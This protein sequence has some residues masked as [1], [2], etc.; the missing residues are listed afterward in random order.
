MVVAGRGLDLLRTCLARSK[1]KKQKAA[2]RVKSLDYA[3]II[4]HLVPASICFF[5]TV[6]ILLR[7]YSPNGSV[8]ERVGTAMFYM[9]LGMMA[10]IGIV[11]GMLALIGIVVLIAVVAVGLC[12]LMAMAVC[13][14]YSTVETKP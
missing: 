14:Y 13:E 3:I 8:M 2:A 11:L 7:S 5:A 10:S 6:G 12:W 9:G 4:E 1:A